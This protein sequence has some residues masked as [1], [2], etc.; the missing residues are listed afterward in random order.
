MQLAIDSDPDFDFDFDF[1]TANL[2]FPTRVCPKTLLGNSEG[3]W[4]GTQ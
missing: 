2:S 3:G 4:G 1:A